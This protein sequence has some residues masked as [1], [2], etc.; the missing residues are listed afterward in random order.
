MLDLAAI[1]VRLKE[2]RGTITQKVIAEEFGVQRSYIANIETGRTQPS[3]EYLLFNATKF[4]I[5]IDWIVRGMEVFYNKDFMKDIMEKLIENKQEWV[6][7]EAVSALSKN[8][9]IKF[10][11]KTFMMDQHDDPILRDM[12]AYLRVIWNGNDKEMQSWL[13]IQFQ[14]CFPDY[15]EELQKNWYPYEDGAVKGA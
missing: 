11:F 8:E 4:N 12:I 13:K 1:G 9:E 10:A 2:I 5:P 3:L 6:L 14:K 7:I 15:L